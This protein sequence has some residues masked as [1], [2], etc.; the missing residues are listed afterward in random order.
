[1]RRVLIALGVLT[2]LMAVPIAATAGGGGGCRE[3]TSGSTTSVTIQYSCFNPVVTEIE[4][5]DQVRWV[6]GDGYMHDVYSI[7]FEASP[8]LQAGDTHSVRFV[9]PGVYPYVCSLHPGMMGTVVV[10]DIAE[11]G[12]AETAARNAAAAAAAGQTTTTTTEAVAEASTGT[13]LAATDTPADTNPLPAMG[14]GAALLGA[15]V[16]LGFVGRRLSTR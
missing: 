6:N 5:G 4:V 8:I 12:A 1:M 13:V 14:L 7:A 16:L 2:A 9:E 15:G 11:H 10:G 3:F